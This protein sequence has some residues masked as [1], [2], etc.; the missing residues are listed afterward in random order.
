MFQNFFHLNITK[1]SIEKDFHEKNTYN[2]DKLTPA[3]Q[4][5]RYEGND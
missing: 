3:D 5:R 1:G 2:V 4:K